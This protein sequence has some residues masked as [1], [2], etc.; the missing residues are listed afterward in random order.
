MPQGPPKKQLKK[1]VRR[2]GPAIGISSKKHGTGKIIPPKNKN[3][4]QRHKLQQV[5]FLLTCSSDDETEAIGD[6][7]R[8]QQKE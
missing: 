4:L 1:Q 5:F 3:E 6:I 2:H 7:K 8:D